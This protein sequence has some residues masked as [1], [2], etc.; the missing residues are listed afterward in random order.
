MGVASLVLGIVGLLIAIIPFLGS[1]AIPVTALA[2]IL[3]FIGRRKATGKGLATA[4][5]VLGLVGSSLS[6]WWIY[7]SHKAADAIQKAAA[8]LPRGQ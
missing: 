3:G 8:E 2:L 6:G 1:Y 5:L 4:G 7:A